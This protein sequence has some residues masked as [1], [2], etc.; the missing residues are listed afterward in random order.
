MIAERLNWYALYVKSRHEFVTQGE[1]VRKGISTYLPAVKKSRQWKDR[2]KF[3]DFPLFPGYCFVHIKPDPEDFISVLKTRGV[4]TL[5][6]AKPGC[7]TPVS[8]EEINSLRLLVESG[9]EFDIY[10]HLKEGARV[11]VKRGPLKGAEG[12]LEKKEEQYMLLVSIKLLGRSV[13]VNICADDIEA[14]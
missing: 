9:R 11:R 10:P 13:G 3:V 7:P 12:T 5:L 8:P 4:V 1:L 14:A 2:K 6:S